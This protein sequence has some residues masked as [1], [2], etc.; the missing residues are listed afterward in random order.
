MVGRDLSHGTYPPRA[1]QLGLAAPAILRAR[2]V[3]VGRELNDLSIEVRRGEIV[4][5]A[6]LK[7]AGA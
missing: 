7:G 1:S 6:G 2:E 3:A 5:L 4:G